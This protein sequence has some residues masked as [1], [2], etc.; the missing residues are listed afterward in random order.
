MRGIFKLLG[1]ILPTPMLVMHSLFPK[2]RFAH[3]IDQAFVRYPNLV[4]VLPIV[5]RKLTFGNFWEVWYHGL[6]INRQIM[7]M[8]N[9]EKFN[10]ANFFKSPEVSL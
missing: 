6:V 9:C 10:F 2:F 5:E 3:I 7:V 4:L 8:E 1:Q